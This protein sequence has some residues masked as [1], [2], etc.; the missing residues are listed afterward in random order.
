MS[1]AE[2]PTHLWVP[3]YQCETGSV[4]VNVNGVWGLVICG[5]CKGEKGWWHEPTS[6]SVGLAAL[7]RYC[8][9]SEERIQRQVEEF[10]KLEDE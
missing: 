4:E 1:A 7:E 3:C 10:R 8:D 2:L 5:V 6:L 9:T